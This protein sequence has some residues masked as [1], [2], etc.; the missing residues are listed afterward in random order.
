M[1][2]RRQAIIWTSGGYFT[3]A[4]ILRPAKIWRLPPNR[5][6]RVKCDPVLHN[7]F[8]YSIYLYHYVKN[9]CLLPGLI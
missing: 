9:L 6:H 2:T 4:Y 3:D 1:P 8:L 7:K 5:D